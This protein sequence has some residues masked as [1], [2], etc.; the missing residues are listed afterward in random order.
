MLL[1][2]HSGL[3]RADGPIVSGEALDGA[4]STVGEVDTWTF[5]ATIGERVVVRIARLTGDNILYPTMRLRAG[6]S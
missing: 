2:T 5:T 1:A 6:E 4:I 3:A